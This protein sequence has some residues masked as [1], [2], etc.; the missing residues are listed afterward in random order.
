MDVKEA[1]KRGGLKTAERGSDYFRKIQKKSAAKR[2]A[3]RKI[4]SNSNG[5]S[6]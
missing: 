6:V 5:V 4:S 2:A 1:G 3:N